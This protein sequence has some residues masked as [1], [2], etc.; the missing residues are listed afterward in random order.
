MAT[1][2]ILQITYA[3]LFSL[4]HALHSQLLHG[5]R[6]KYTKAG[7]ARVYFALLNDGYDELEVL[8]ITPLR[9]LP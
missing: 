2:S 4:L 8:F 3:Q 5:A 9:L 1:H 7:L 6:L